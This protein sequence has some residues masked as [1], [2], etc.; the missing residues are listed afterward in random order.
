MSTAKIRGLLAHEIEIHTF[1]AVA[2]EESPLALLS[3]GLGNSL[4][5]EEGLA[6]YYAQETARHISANEPNKT[7][8]GT[9]ATG[10]ASGAM[11]KPYT[12]LKLLSFLEGVN[13]VR[14]LLAEGHQTLSEIQER[15]QKNAQSRCLRTWR[16]VTNLTRPGICST[17]DHVYLRGYLAVNQALENNEI[18][19]EQLMVGAVGLHH[20][21]DMR[22][23][24]IVAPRIIHQ[25]LAI[26]PN[27]E[28]SISRFIE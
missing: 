25:K 19:F 3:V 27:L 12:F 24:D 14:S 5:T 21:D 4:E 13:V 18:L 16:G 22:E 17:K 2:G 7:W 6:I 9:L 26:D 1:R 11:G 28:E 10:L 8:I 20:T 23:L 15:A